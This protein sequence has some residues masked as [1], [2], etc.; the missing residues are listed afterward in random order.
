MGQSTREPR[1]LPEGPGLPKPACCCSQP[2][3]RVPWPRT[4]HWPKTTSA[5]Q[6]QQSGNPGL[7]RRLDR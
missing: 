4:G 3:K 2:A 1:A 7:L 5:Q 6:V